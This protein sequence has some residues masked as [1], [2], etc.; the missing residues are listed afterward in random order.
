MAGAASVAPVGRPKAKLAADVPAVTRRVRKLLDAVHGGNL[1]A[2]HR[3]T[4]VPYPT[5]R[6]LYA[7]RTV[8]PEL[9]TLDQLRA[10]YGVSL[11]WFTDRE[12]SDEVPAAGRV[13]L[14]PPHPRAAG[15]GGPG[16]GRALR[17]VLVPYAARTLFAVFARLQTWLERQPPAPERPVV[18]EATGDTLA[19][20]LTTFLLQPLLAAE[21]LGEEVIPQPGASGAPAIGDAAWVARLEALGAMW[22]TTLPRIGGGL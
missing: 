9:A 1:A 20:R 6:D 14:L 17:E 2:A 8:N 5:L 3:V 16:G 7:G 19:F 15:G 10:P 13:V 18:G 4:G 12:A 21:K 22:R 11:S